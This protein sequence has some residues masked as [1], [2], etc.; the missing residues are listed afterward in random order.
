MFSHEFFNSA[1]CGAAENFSHFLNPPV[2]HPRT[3]AYIRG[4]KGDH[5]G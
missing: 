5:G 1:V 2:R 3:F 4:A